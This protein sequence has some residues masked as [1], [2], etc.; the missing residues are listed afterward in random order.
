MIRNVILF[1]DGRYAQDKNRD[2]YY[3]MR[4]TLRSTDKNNAKIR[5]EM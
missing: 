5:L 3:A 1:S 4:C 2:Y